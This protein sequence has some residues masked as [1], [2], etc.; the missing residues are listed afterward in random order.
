MKKIIG[1]IA[2]VALVCI[3]T[4]CDRLKDEP[5]NNAAPKAV[6]K[7]NNNIVRLPFNEAIEKCKSDEFYT[8]ACL[9]HHGWIES[10]EKTNNNWRE[11]YWKESQ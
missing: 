6:V 1:L 2:L 10:K 7:A 9:A 4:G 11:S 3:A 5:K 8:Y